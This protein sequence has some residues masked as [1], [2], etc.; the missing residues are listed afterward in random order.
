MNFSKA[1]SFFLLMT[2]L[3]VGGANGASNRSDSAN[4]NEW[5]NSPNVEFASNGD[6]A[7][8]YP[9]YYHPTN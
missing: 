9:P 4:L 5:A 7:S 3:V 2:A 1:I 6:R 8:H